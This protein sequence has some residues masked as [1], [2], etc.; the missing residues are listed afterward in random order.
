MDRSYILDSYIKENEENREETLKA[1]DLLD[2]F[3][4]RIK[5]SKT[6]EEVKKELD[7]YYQQN[8]LPTE[9]KDEMD[10][11]ISGLTD[12]TDIYTVCN[13]LE[14]VLS[15]Y[16]DS[17]EKEFQKSD[18]TVYEI[19]EEVVEKRVEKIDIQED[20]IKKDLTKIRSFY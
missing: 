19:K 8:N 18:D 20:N 5:G 15:T 16:L 17:K 14:N 1:T 10:K 11:V 12:T 6:I 2:N 7:I 4:F 3:K 9:V 13:R